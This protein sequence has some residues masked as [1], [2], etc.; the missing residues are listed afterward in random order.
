MNKNRKCSLCDGS[1]YIE[2]VDDIGYDGHITMVPCPDPDGVHKTGQVARLAR[3]S[4][5]LPSEMSV[6]LDHVAMVGD[7]AQMV[8]VARQFVDEPFGFLTLWGG[9]GNG[10]TLV[11]QAIVNEFRKRHGVVGTYVR[12]YDLLEYVRTGYNAPPHDNANVRYERLKALPILAIDEVD[13][14]RMTDFAYEFRTAFLDDRYRL[15]IAR[16][17]HTVFAMNCDPSDLPGDL[18]DRLRDGRFVIFHNCDG[19]MRPEMEWDE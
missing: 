14:A 17:G 16:Q 9:Y 10:K 8:K 18:G 1:G 7:T 19:S 11:L 15:A 12:M 5:L 6:T 2:K 3:I 4:G 13:A